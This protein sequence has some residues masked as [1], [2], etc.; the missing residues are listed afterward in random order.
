MTGAQLLQQ[1]LL[2]H[3]H[4][5][6]AHRLYARI[7]EHIAHRLPGMSPQRVVDMALRRCAPPVALRRV[8]VAGTTY[9]VPAL[10]S[11]HRGWSMAATWLVEGARR[12]QRRRR[13]QGGFAQSLATLV[14]DTCHGHGYACDQYVETLRGAQAHRASLRYRWW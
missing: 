6:K 1:R 4:A 5:T 13:V 7:L 8:R 3:G 9:P 14:V 12:H 11:L 2:Q 10:L